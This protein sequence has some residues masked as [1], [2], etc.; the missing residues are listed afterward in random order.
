MT[1][2]SLIRSNSVRSSSVRSS[3]VRSNR[4]HGSRVGNRE[5]LNPITRCLLFT[6]LLAA[7]CALTDGS[8]VLPGL[9]RA[10]L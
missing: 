6:I 4:F 1:R 5:I 10:S 8:G 3:S 7:G 9:G 2:N